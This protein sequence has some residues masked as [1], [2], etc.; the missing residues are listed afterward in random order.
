[1]HYLIDYVVSYQPYAE[2]C[3]V[4]RDLQANRKVGIPRFQY[5][6]G[7]MVKK[8]ETRS[9]MTLEVETVGTYRIQRPSWTSSGG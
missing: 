7:P 4:F 6:K 1:M 8:K 9:W 2:C 5:N 3:E